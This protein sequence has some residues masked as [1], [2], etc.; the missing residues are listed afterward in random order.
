MGNNPSTPESNTAAK[1]V[2]CQDKWKGC[3]CGA[4]GDG[5]SSSDVEGG[6]LDDEEMDDSSS[7]GGDD[8]HDLTC[9]P[10]CYVHRTSVEQ[11]GVGR[12]GGRIQFAVKVTSGQCD[13]VYC[14]EAQDP[15]EWERKYQTRKMMRSIYDKEFPDCFYMDNPSDE[16]WPKVHTAITEEERGFKARKSRI[17]PQFVDAKSMQMMLSAMRTGSYSLAAGEGQMLRCFTKCQSVS[18]RMSLAEA[19]LIFGFLLV[20]WDRMSLAFEVYEEFR[21]VSEDNMGCTQR[22]A[23]YAEAAHAMQSWRCECEGAW[24][25]FVRCVFY[26]RRS[27]EDIAMDEGCCFKH[28]GAG[29]CPDEPAKLKAPRTSTTGKH[30]RL[31]L[32]KEYR[33]WEKSHVGTLVPV[34]LKQ[35]ALDARMEESTKERVEPEPIL[36]DPPAKQKAGGYSVWRK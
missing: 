33:L 5:R 8:Y 7:G 14:V 13:E 29:S 2:A 27:W 28:P 10:F 15:K 32:V 22:N 4:I 11:Q 26:I 6:V 16:A 12:S 20:G 24:L 25:K 23:G 31:Q 34:H 35:A 21:T 1:D 9:R 30:T 19:W 17:P 3:S 18:A 36:I